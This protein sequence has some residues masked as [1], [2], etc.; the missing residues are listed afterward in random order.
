MILDVRT[1]EEFVTAHY[2]GSVNIPLDMLPSIILEKN[3]QKDEPILVC[4]ESGGRSAY[5]VMILQELGF[6]QVKNGGSWKSL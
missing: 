4:C 5:A 2:K 3:I 6:T 1:Q